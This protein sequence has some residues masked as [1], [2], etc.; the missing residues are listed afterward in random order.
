[1]LGNSGGYPHVKNYKI[2]PPASHRL[3]CEYKRDA[4]ILRILY[5][6][7]NMSCIVKNLKLISC[8]T[9]VKVVLRIEIDNEMSVT[10][11]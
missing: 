7:V 8:M 5:T 2:R 6:F 4:V 9:L 11:Q 3:Y 10:E 1:M